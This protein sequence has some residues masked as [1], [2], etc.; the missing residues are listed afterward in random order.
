[1]TLYANENLEP[2]YE[3]QYYIGLNGTHYPANVPRTSIPNL[4]PVAE[5]DR[6]TDPDLVVTGFIINSEFVQIWQTRTKNN[7]ELA[8]DLANKKYALA[9]ARYAKEVGGIT[10]SNVPIQTDRESRANLMGARILAKEDSNYSLT[11]KI[12]GGFVTLNAAQIIAIADAVAVHVKRCF[13]AEAEVYADIENVD[14]VESA[15]EDAY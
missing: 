2:V 4:H 14:D 6:P 15:F 5:T 13:E 3:G 8:A 9:A 7:A 10:I 1:M 11:W 12:E